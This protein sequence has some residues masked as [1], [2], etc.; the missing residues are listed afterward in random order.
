MVVLKVHKRV[1]KLCLLECN[2]KESLRQTNHY[3]ME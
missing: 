1:K 3:E 2:V